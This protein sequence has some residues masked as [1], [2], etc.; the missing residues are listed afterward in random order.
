MS[1][2]LKK[3][4]LDELKVGS[5]VSTYCVDREHEDPIWTGT[6]TDISAKRQRFLVE[7]TSNGKTAVYDG[8]GSFVRFSP[9][10]SDTVHCDCR[11]GELMPLTPEKESLST[12]GGVISALFESWDRLCRAVNIPSGELYQ[13]RQEITYLL[14]RYKQ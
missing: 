1:Q 6:V 10:R 11:F 4:F 3:D 7:W 12:R 14:Q 5:R 2:N 9:P 13:I 8:S